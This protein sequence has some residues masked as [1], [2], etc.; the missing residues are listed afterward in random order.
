M[1]TKTPLLLPILLIFSS[2]ST[3]W[4]ESNTTKAVLSEIGTM[5]FNS[6][7]QSFTSESKV[8]F[9]HS[10]AQ[11]LWQNPQVTAGSIK[12]IADAWSADRLHKL[13]TEALKAYAYANP[14]NSKQQA[15]V[16]D[17]IASAISHAA[18]QKGL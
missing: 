8:D 13:S 5:V 3:E 12:R 10:M 9:G 4:L 6:A 16:T 2:C 17:A 18:E 14:K 7:I 1:T 11:G 15:Q